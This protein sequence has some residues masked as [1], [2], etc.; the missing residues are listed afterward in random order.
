MKKVRVPQWVLC[1]AA[2]EEYERAQEALERAKA[3]YESALSEYDRL[4]FGVSVPQ[5]R[6]Y[7]A[8]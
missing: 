6:D 4:S 3:R 7:L 8:A 5:L 1:E 2:R